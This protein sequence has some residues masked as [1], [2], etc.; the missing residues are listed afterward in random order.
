[1][2]VLSWSGCSKGLIAP[3][4][5]SNSA[6]LSNVSSKARWKVLPGGSCIW[7]H[8]L[9][10]STII[11]CWGTLRLWLSSSLLSA[12]LANRDVSSSLMH[13]LLQSQALAWPCLPR[14]QE[15]MLKLWAKIHI[16]PFKLLLSAHLVMV[17]RKAHR[18]GIEVWVWGHCYYYLTTW[19]IGLWDWAM[20]GMWNSGLELSYTAVSRT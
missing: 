13:L 15:C 6:I 17:I 19:F 11:G 14:H 9:T 7:I 5:Q 2:S 3:L 10:G 4:E 8:G 1:M 18:I 12:F 20:G 16:F